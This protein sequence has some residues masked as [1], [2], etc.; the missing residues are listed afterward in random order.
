MRKGDLFLGTSTDESFLEK[1]EHGGVVTSLLAFA[2]RERLVDGVFAVQPGQNR[3]QGFPVYMTEPEEVV[4]CAG[5]YHFLTPSLAKN[6]KK[7][8]DTHQ[9]RVAVVCKSCDARALVELAK[10][11]QINLENILMIGL[12][13]SGTL[14]PVPH[15]QM[16]SEMGIDPYLLEWED[17]E[18]NNLVLRFK[19]GEQRV[20][21]LDELE[22]QG[23]G[24]RANCRR[25]E[26]PVP[27]MADLA[28]G[29]WGLEPGTGGTTVIEVC[30]DKGKQLLERAAAVKIVEL[31]RPTEEQTNRRETEERDKVDSAR[32]RQ[33]EDF[34][35]PEEKFYW[36]SQMDRCI[37]CYSCRDVCPLCHCKRCVLEREDPQSVEKGVVPPPFTF[38]TIRLMHVAAYCVNCGQCEDV[39][40]ADIPL[41]RLAHN[42][43][44][45]ASS[46]FDYHPGVNPDDPLP[47]SDIPEEERRSQSPDLVKPS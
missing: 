20:F 8:L 33:A 41:S 6:V 40:S 2:L 18:G 26:H 14:A 35:R 42:L 15:I 5:S 24:R 29:K 32:S 37:K 9:R 16:L 38:G 19:D 44:K 25:C 28:C 30:S 22:E 47:Y 27:R 21:K 10:I 7:Y 46:L 17:I 3:Y 13:C 45:V 34:A 23:L 11:N 4:G 12:N 36:F 43:S 1:G 39:C 31:Q